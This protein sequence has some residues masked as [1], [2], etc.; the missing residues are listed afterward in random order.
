MRDSAVSS[1]GA[2]LSQQYACTNIYDILTFGS[3]SPLVRQLKSVLLA[4]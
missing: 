3:K 1:Q 4:V 2:L